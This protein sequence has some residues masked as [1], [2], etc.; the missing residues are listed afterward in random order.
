LFSLVDS[1][2][3]SSFNDNQLQ[4][5][6]I[7][8]L[9]VYDTHLETAIKF[10]LKN[11]WIIGDARKLLFIIDGY[12]LNSTKISLSSS[13]DECKTNEFISSTYNLIT[14]SHT[15]ISL[16]VQLSPPPKVRSSVY[17][18]F[19]YLDNSNNN[20]N[21]SIWN[22]KQLPS[23][24]FTFIREKELIPF[25]AKICLILLLFCVSGFFSG[26]NLG[27]MSL[28]VNDLDIIAES[29]D[30]NLRYY[31]RRVL[32]LR[33]RGNFLLCSIVIANVLVNSLGTVLLDS[34]V[35]G[36][37]AVIGSTA[38]IVLMGEII[39]Q[40]ICSRFG[41]IIGAHTHMITW[42][43]MIITG[44]ISFP[45]GLILDKILGQEVTASYTREQIAG[46]LKRIS[47]DIE[48]PELDIIT[49][50]LSLRKK[51]VVETMTHLTDVFMLDKDRKTDAELL[52][53]VHKHGFSRIPVYSVE[54][55]N[56]IGIV[57]LRDFA[58]ITPEQQN[59]TV[60]HVM[61]FHSHP[62]GYTKPDACLYNL[63]QEFLK[64]RYHI[65]LVQELATDNPNL[66]P[67]F[68]AVGIIT[69][70]DVIEDM[71]QREIIEETD[72]FTDNRSKIRNKRSYTQDYTA[73]IKRAVKGPSINPALK[74]AVFQF[75][76]TNIQSFTAGFISQD[77]LKAL[78]NYNVYAIIKRQANT[79]NSIY[80]YK[81]GFQYDIFTLIIQGNATL[82][83]GAERIMS[84][85]GPFSSFAAN[86]LISEDKSVKELHEA[87]F[88]S[89]I[90]LSKIEEYFPVFTPD[91]N[92]IVHNE[93]HVLQIHRYIWLAAVK[94]T[95]RQRNEPSCKNSTPEQ[96]LSDAIDEIGS[97]SQP[98]IDKNN[99]TNFHKISIFHEKHPVANGGGITK[100]Y[101][102]Y[103]DGGDDS[104]APKNF[105]IEPIAS[106][107]KTSVITLVC[108]PSVVRN[109]IL[110]SIPSATRTDLPSESEESNEFNSSMHINRMFDEDLT[111]N[112]SKLD[113]KIDDYDNLL[114]TRS[115]PDHGHQ[116]STP[117][118]QSSMTGHGHSQSDKCLLIF[119]DDQPTPTLQIAP[120]QIQQENIHRHQYRTS[121]IN[122]RSDKKS[123]KPY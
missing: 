77:I 12:N 10:D 99:L 68:H 91:Y 52:L 47:A 51:T 113:E 86:A 5:P 89:S 111:Q 16:E 54:R 18:C 98:P 93:L 2:Q 83:S 20:S 14:T 107:I 49:G 58:L 100:V 108:D 8:H 118:E 110:L 59:L 4:S 75:L 1:I 31:A 102:P 40:A 95:Y 24:F 11:G 72:L 115:Y 80:L 28:S 81:K 61:E 79:T 78:L 69:L 44:I 45:L 38:M 15:A 48:K 62:V 22:S 43:S 64:S 84:T 96:L 57:K 17:L 85:V 56:V 42:A 106:P 65:A 97:T 87:L 66:D 114:T 122:N 9:L 29:D 73:L 67:V 109:P 117:Y 33:K 74:V 50:V 60:K 104:S 70:E 90:Q 101:H 88:H 76:N 19:S 112:Q 103:C 53:E 34:L 63:M 116:T 36:L 121:S 6:Q 13:F 46:L 94:A 21:S 71:L 41:L 35:H 25:A 23:P 27:L 119:G 26:L 105:D 55:N 32:P 120:E 123:V 39:P 37:Y 82:E 3:Y 92:L 30:A 7:T